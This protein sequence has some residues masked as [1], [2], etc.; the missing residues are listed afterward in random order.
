MLQFIM[1]IIAIVFGKLVWDILNDYRQKMQTAGP[2][3]GQKKRR[4][5]NGEVIDLSNVWINM[6][7]LPYRKRNYLL[8]GRELALYKLFT[9]VLQNSPYVAFP[10][11]NLED[12]V[13]VSL[14]A[15]NRTEYFNRIKNRY[16]DVLICEKDELQ[17]VLIIIGEG[18]G[19]P[20]KKQ[21]VL[22]DRFVRSAAEAA[23]IKYLP[24]S[25]NKLPNEEHLITLL[26]NSGL[27][28]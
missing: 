27:D 26:R 23:G 12:V 17:P 6:D 16:V 4:G 14:E 10:R 25:L 22:E 24:I 11:V 19:E 7:D 15:D 1:L 5:G 13:T 18:Q 28:I 9:T 21:Q 2:I 8:S 20:R 3:L